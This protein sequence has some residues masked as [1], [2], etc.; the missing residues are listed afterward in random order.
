MDTSIILN[1]LDISLEDIED[2]TQLY[3]FDIYLLNN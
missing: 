1:E 2:V 3:D